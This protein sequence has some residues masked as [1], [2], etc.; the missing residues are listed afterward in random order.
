MLICCLD[1]SCNATGLAG[2]F[3]QEKINNSWGVPVNSDQSL[4]A[5]LSNFTTSPSPNSSVT[6]AFSQHRLSPTLSDPEFPAF[7]ST[8]MPSTSNNALHLP[9]RRV[10]S[11][12][13]TASNCSVD[14]GTLLSPA[15]SNYA[16]TPAVNIESGY[17][18][19]GTADSMAGSPDTALASRDD[20]QINA[21]Q[22]CIV[23]C[24]S[25]VSAALVPCGHHLFCYTCAKD[26]VAKSPPQC[27]SCRQNALRPLL[28][29]Q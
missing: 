11:E 6:S 23:C 15:S 2:G 4:P 22:R 25:V 24:K 13:S 3:S 8:L 26:I 21:Q 9:V 5:Y 20:S 14:I 28:I 29:K 7:T 17:S 18:S 16:S 27:P 1:R 19:S 10:E 12:D